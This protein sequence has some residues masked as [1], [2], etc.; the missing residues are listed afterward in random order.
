[1]RRGEATRENAWMRTQMRDKKK[2]NVQSLSL[3]AIDVDP[4]ITQK[5]RSQPD[6]L[7]ALDGLRSVG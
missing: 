4:L 1:M 5:W 7:A 6:A 2:V 3:A